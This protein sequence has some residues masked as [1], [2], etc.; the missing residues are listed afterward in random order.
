MNATPATPVE[1]EKFRRT[2]HSKVRSGCQACRGDYLATIVKSLTGELES[3]VPAKS[4]PFTFPIDP[5]PN[6]TNQAHA[7][8]QTKWTSPGGRDIFWTSSGNGR[9]YIA[10]A[11]FMMDFGSIWSIKRLKIIPPSAMPLLPWVV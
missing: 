1:K 8:W 3:F 2:S 6:H 5:H 10:L 7:S 4:L 9:L 11:T